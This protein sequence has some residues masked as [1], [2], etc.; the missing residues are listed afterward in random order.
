MR[1]SDWSSDVCSSDLRSKKLLTGGGCRIFVCCHEIARG[2]LVQ[3]DR[4]FDR[5]GGTRRTILQRGKNVLGQ[6][7]QR[8]EPLNFLM[9]LGDA[10]GEI[11]C[12]GRLHDAAREAPEAP[13]AE[14][15]RV[16][17]E[18]VSRGR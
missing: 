15:R 10:R 7:E 3:L 9:R 8:V 16:G 5:D 11:L 13:R 18:G 6:G 4:V 1:I 14:T 12:R 2:L 17:T